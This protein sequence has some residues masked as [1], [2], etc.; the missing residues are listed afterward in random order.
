MTKYSWLNYNEYTYIQTAMIRLVLLVEPSNTL[1][2]E[3]MANILQKPIWN[4]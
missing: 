4:G 2:P 3:H 1:R